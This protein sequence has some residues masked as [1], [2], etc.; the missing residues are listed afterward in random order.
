MPPNPGGG[1]VRH[2]RMVPVGNLDVSVAGG[3]PKGIFYVRPGARNRQEFFRFCRKH[4]VIVSKGD[5]VQEFDDG[6]LAYECAAPSAALRE[7]LGMSCVSDSHAVVR[8]RPPRT[9][10]GTEHTPWG[11]VPRAEA[12]VQRT[13][14]HVPIPADA[15]AGV[16]RV[17][18]EGRAGKLARLTMRDREAV[19][20]MSRDERDALEV[21]QAAERPPST[22]YADTLAMAELGRLY[23]SGQAY[24][25]RAKSLR[26]QLGM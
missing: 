6:T 26:K 8:S 7:L 22:D 17:V 23:A 4:G 12:E 5:C 10:F 25:D 16:K 2:R 15:S 18:R 20:A 13:P 9:S 19:K 3:L 11:E 14:E 24:S 1:F 21:R